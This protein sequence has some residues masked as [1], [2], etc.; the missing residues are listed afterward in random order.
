LKATFATTAQ[1]QVV[2]IKQAL[3]GPARYGVFPGHAEALENALL[4]IIRNAHRQF[5]NLRIAFL[6][7]RT[8]GGYATTP[9]SPEPYAYESAFAVRG[10]I[11][12]Q[13]GGDP[14]LNCDPQRGAVR[15]PVLLWGPYLWANGD[16][17]R[18]ADGLA[19]RRA[20]F[21]DDGTH[22]SRQGRRKVAELLLQFFTNDQFGK[23]VFLR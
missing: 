9:L 22:P 19:W 1:V 3:A 13:M 5:P 16:V 23:E 20:D 14:E 18:Q 6:S 21:H 2:W 12:R 17:P 7:S 4:R 15:A 11:Q 10:V 8:Y